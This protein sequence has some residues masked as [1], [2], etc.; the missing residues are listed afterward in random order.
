[1]ANIR[2]PPDS[3]SPRRASF[4]AS[5]GKKT[6]YHVGN[7]DAPRKKPHVSYEGSG[8]SVSL[9]PEEWRK[10]ARGKVSGDTW[11]LS[12]EDPKFLLANKANQK[13][14]RQWAIDNGWLKSQTRY[15][16]S[17][18]DDEMNDTMA[19]TFD[20]L[21][22]AKEEAE[23][24]GVEVEEIDSVALDSKGLTYWREA[25]SS[26]PSNSLAESFAILWYAE[27]KGYDGVWWNDKL[28]PARL[29]APRG[30]IFQSKL[31]EWSKT[32]VEKPVSASSLA[33]GGHADPSSEHQT[34]NI[35]VEKLWKE[36]VAGPDAR[37]GCGNG[38]LYFKDALEKLLKFKDKIDASVVLG[39]IGIE[40]DEIDAETEIEA[41]YHASSLKYWFNNIT[42]GSPPLE[43]LPS[44]HVWDGYHRL[45][46]AMARGVDTLPAITINEEGK[47]EQPVA[48]LMAS[49][50]EAPKDFR[51]MFRLPNK[52]VPDLGEQLARGV[53]KGV[54][55]ITDSGK[56]LMLRMLGQ[57]RNAMLVM[58]GTA[59]LA[60]NDLER[61]EYDNPDYLMA[62]DMAVAQRIMGQSH[63]KQSTIERILRE[64]ASFR[65]PVKDFMTAWGNLDVF[66]SEQLAEVPLDSALDFAVELFALSKPKV[67]EAMQRN[68]ELGEDFVQE[69]Y[70]PLLDPDNYLKAVQAG[71]L[72]FGRSFIWE[73][74]WLV[75]NKT[76][77]IP[78]GSRLFVMKEGAL[79]ESAKQTIEQ[80]QLADRYPVRYV[81]ASKMERAGYALGQH[82]EQL[83]K[84]RWRKQ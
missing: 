31:P 30:V 13:K 53:L 19:M 44:G 6:V 76:L 20:S 68:A 9:H 23:A 47:P 11:A 3:A 71:L 84:E 4:S 55:G 67:E 42:E 77:R 39:A 64:A 82:A 63:T 38:Y 69:R 45:V 65:S 15:Q 57:N 2:K 49:S 48:R 8:L 18:F 81:D 46:A 62:N 21:D 7:L 37:W 35:N 1:M 25:F 14:A 17:W 70:G 34:Y 41:K 73:G 29:S 27:Y 24:Y 83:T 60:A 16:V 26:R 28:D 51:L 36:V 33:E 22:E 61:V 5:A 72:A 78:D 75:N 54:A 12:K 43:I 50:A 74:E 66:P 40:E 56:V 10:I 58:P 59:V 32:K 79:A 80:Y 52:D